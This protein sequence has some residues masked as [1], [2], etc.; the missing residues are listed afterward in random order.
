[1][2]Q[3]AYDGGVIRFRMSNRL[4]VPTVGIAKIESDMT[5]VTVA[6]AEQI[7]EDD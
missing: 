5:E 4:W 1:M 7:G 2:I 6:A 3:L